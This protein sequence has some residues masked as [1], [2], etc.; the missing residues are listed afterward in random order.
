MFDAHR[1]DPEFGH[2]LL[3]D[4]ARAAGHRVGDRT[5]WR[6]CAANHWW[7]VFGKKRGANGKR[8]GPPAHDDLVRREF[9]AAAPN[10]LWLTDITEHPTAEGK[11][12]LCAIK[13]VFSGRIVG[14]SMSSRMKSQLAVDALASAVAR[15]GSDIAGCTVHSDRGSQFRSRRFLDQLRRHQL[16]GSMG[17]VAS[18]GDNAA[19]ESFFSLLQKNVLDR[20]R[21]TTRAELR[22]AIITWIERTYHRRRRQA[23]LGRLTPIEYETINS[24]QVALA[25]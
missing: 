9:T 21:W 6:I 11:L 15:R 16:A 5:V 14:Y 3:G 23:R 7:S 18:A 20:R 13:D 22:Q 25:A 19:M 2:R 12:Y 1:D 17:Q 24:T 10:R 4:E 8:P